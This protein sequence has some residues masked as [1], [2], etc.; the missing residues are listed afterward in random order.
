MQSFEI[1]VKTNQETHVYS[2]GEKFS[3]FYFFLHEQQPFFHREIARNYS[4]KQKYCAE[5]ISI[6]PRNAATFHRENRFSAVKEKL[7]AG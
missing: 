3:P 5:T 6:S 1:E 4:L 2:A 7:S